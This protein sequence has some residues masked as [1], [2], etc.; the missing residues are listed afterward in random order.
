MDLFKKIIDF[1]QSEKGK[2]QIENIN[3]EM[4]NISNNLEKLSLALKEIEKDITKANVHQLREMLNEFEY[5]FIS[6]DDLLEIAS[7]KKIVKFLYDPQLPNVGIKKAKLNFIS[8]FQNRFRLKMEELNSRYKQLESL[9]SSS[10]DDIAKLDSYIRILDSDESYKR[11]SI[12]ELNELF[13]YVENS[14]ISRKLVLEFISYITINRLKNDELYIN[15]D[16]V[17][18]VNDVEEEIAKNAEKIIGS[19]EKEE[20][21]IDLSFLSEKEKELLNQIE[22]LFEE[23]GIS[24]V[25]DWYD[26]VKNSIEG[27]GLEERYEYYF[28][29]GEIEWL[30]V[31]ADYYSKLLPNI[32]ENK[33]EVLGVV[34]FVIASNDKINRDKL[35]ENEKRQ[36]ALKEFNENVVMVDDLLSELYSDAN[37][38]YDGLSDLDVET[39]NNFVTELNSLSNST[40]DKIANNDISVKELE[41]INLKLIKLMAKYDEFAKSRR[42]ASEHRDAYNLKTAKTLILLLKDKDNNFVPVSEIEKELLQDKNTVMNEEFQKAIVKISGTGMSDN[43]R[44]FKT[45]EVTYVDDKEKEHSL[46]DLFGFDV[47]RIRN[48]SRGRTGYVIVPVNE[49]NRKKLTEVYGDNIFYQNYNSIILIVNSIFCSSD[50]Y[51]YKEFKKN[52]SDNLDYIKYII[53]LFKDPNSSVE[54]MMGVIE[55][56][57]IECKKISSG[58]VRRGK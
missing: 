30:I 32:V 47:D 54:K 41:I 1:I 35:V 9:L 14:P 33:E 27:F 31:A 37:A 34:R 46:K 42:S 8:E 49:I 10:N 7:I 43:R 51:E 29:N 56:S 52:I 19:E 44:V 6:E 23:N 36:K 50:H 12:D 16:D 48:V 57:A 58:Y 3:V 45:S 11:C 28:N 38:F 2:I 24:N 40:M 15:V 4:L 18:Q 39:M 17:S 21:K 20:I 53:D 13:D 25:E 26:I 55:E 22:K 5:D